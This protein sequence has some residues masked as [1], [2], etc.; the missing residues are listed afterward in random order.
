L[1]TKLRAINRSYVGLGLCVTGIFAVAV[2][3]LAMSPVNTGS[4]YKLSG[5]AS[6]NQSQPLTINNATNQP[7]SQSTAGMSGHSGYRVQG[8]SQPETTPPVD[9]QSYSEILPQP[10][11]VPHCR[12]YLESASQ[13]DVCP[14]CLDES[15]DIVACGC[16]GNQNSMPCVM[17]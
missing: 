12:Y 3:L 10:I 16:G 6:A 9:N 7:F 8:S 15:S 14:R 11:K 13:P 1:F 4:V 2:L 5:R 17:P